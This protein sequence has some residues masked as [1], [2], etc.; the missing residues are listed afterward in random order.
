METKYVR[1]PFDVEMAKKITNGEV[2]GRVVTRDDGNARI[3]CWDAEGDQPI[4]ALIKYHDKEYPHSFC[5]NGLLQDG[6]CLNG[7]LMLEIPEYMTF[8]DGDIL[9]SDCGAFV[10]NGNYEFYRESVHYGAY[11]GINSCGGLNII[12]DKILEEKNSSWTSFKGTRLATEQEKQK[13]IEALKASKEPKA[14]ECLKMLGIK[15]KPECKFKPFDK[16]LARD[17]K[18]NEWKIDIFREFTADGGSE[19][20]RYNCF[21]DNWNYCIPYNDQTKHLLGTN[22]NWEE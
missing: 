11:C 21:Y 13:L 6:D 2:E 8:K 12:G 7:D 5:L 10:Y 1:V 20:Y 3:I 17:S 14:K 19:G 16:V 15:V 22:D 4:I 9:A 18:S